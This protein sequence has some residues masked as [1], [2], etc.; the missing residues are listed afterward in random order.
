M[1]VY[2]GEEFE[3]IARCFN[4]QKPLDI[5][6]GTGL[7]PIYCAD[8]VRGWEKAQRAWG[9][10]LIVLALVIYI[11]SVTIGPKLLEWNWPG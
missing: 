2:W 1:T 11:L 8:C 3:M 5:G 7:D 6:D 4:C 9:T 10:I